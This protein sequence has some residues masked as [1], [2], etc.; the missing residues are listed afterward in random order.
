MAMGTG[1]KIA[2][3]CGCLV[4]LAGAA[5]IGV[6]GMGAFWAKRKI[7]EATGGLERMTARTDEI[8]RWERKANANAYTPPAD[9]VIP[10]ERFLK[11]LETRK[12]IH[13]VYERYEA[14]L[15]E[16]QRKAE[17]SGDKLRPS[18]LWS[19]GGTLAAAFNDIRLAQ[20]KALA[21]LGMSEREYRDIQL[22][23]YKSAWASS[24]EAESGRL[25]AEAVTQSTAEAARKMDAAMRAGLESA[26]KEGVPGAGSLSDEDVRKLHEHLAQAGEEAG[27][28]LEVP[29]ANVELFRR[30]EADIK[31]YAMNGLA[32]IGL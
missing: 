13:S 25:P 10:E 14:E 9:R 30:H 28:A 2:L 22:A 15:R 18:D 17:G 12:R 6:V 3:G 32:Y 23:V 26:R 7:T 19:A 31:K 5:T 1:S 16:I 20:V 24:A 4:L 11:F 8:D 21:E 27:Q 29:R